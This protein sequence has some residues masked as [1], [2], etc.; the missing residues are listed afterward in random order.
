M[1]TNNPKLT[2]VRR[3]GYWIC[4]VD[5]K[6][7]SRAFQTWKFSQADQNLNCFNTV[8]HCRPLNSLLNQYLLYRFNSANTQLVQDTLDS[9]GA[10]ISSSGGSVNSQIVLSLW[11]LSLIVI[12]FF[13]CLWSLSH[14]QACDCFSL[15]FLKI[16]LRCLIKLSVRNW[17]L[18][19]YLDLN[20]VS[21]C[22]VFKFQ[23]ISQL[24]IY[25]CFDFKLLTT[26]SILCSLQ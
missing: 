25:L 9:G 6:W 5:W 14:S 26:I 7:N 3:N 18:R 24:L 15:L 17:T 8:E 23:S 19:R 21:F 2:R 12:R 11:F 22:F 10:R 13:W 1:L 4:K 16:S 20:Q